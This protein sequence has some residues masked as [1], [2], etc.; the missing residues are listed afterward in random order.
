M[1][2]PWR[3]TSGVDWYAFSWS[4]GRSGPPVG[5][6][7]GRG[8][9][10]SVVWS[11]SRSRADLRSTGRSKKRCFRVVW[12][13]K[14]VQIG[15]S[16]SSVTADSE[17][18]RVTARVENSSTQFLNYFLSVLRPAFAHEIENDIVYFV[19]GSPRCRGPWGKSTLAVSR[20]ARCTLFNRTVAAGRD[21]VWRLGNFEVDSRPSR[22]WWCLMYVK[23]PISETSAFEAPKTRKSGLPWKSVPIPTVPVGEILKLAL[24][25]PY[26]MK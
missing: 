23:R 22:A 24:K 2:G 13:H 19:N 9:L 16:I 18:E 20:L 15:S 21:C 5:G 6:R 14:L 12:R 8:I 17:G 25:T 11:G 3:H 7:R 1:G 10:L 26:F 4:T